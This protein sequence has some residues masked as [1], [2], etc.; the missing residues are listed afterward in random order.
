MR[1]GKVQMPYIL[2]LTDA[3]GYLQLSETLR[4]LSQFFLE[5]LASCH[6]PSDVVRLPWNETP[7]F[8]PIIPLLSPFARPLA[9]YLQERGFLVRPITH[10]TVPKG[11][12]RVRVC[13]HANNTEDE[14]SALL[15]CIQTWIRRDNAH[16]A[17]RL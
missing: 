10:P 4:E 14:I 6:F 13:L 16:I 12:D 3:P 2:N 15:D 9:L 5:R 11:Q 1:S 8:T 7:L 17:N